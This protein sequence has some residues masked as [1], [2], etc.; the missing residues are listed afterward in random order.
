M[1]HEAGFEPT[2]PAFGAMKM[3]GV[4]QSWTLVK[5]YAGNLSLANGG[6]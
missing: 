3:N 4:K 1:V 2:P 6:K 5:V